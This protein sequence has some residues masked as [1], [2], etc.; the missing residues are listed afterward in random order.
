MIIATSR[1]D[2][3]KLQEELHE[4]ARVQAD[5]IIQNAERQIQQQTARSVAEIR[6]EAVDLSLMI[7]SKL[8]RRNLTKEDNDGL[9]EDAL[10]QIESQ[11][12]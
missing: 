6:R 4:K 7:A 9:I 2:A 11:Q 12:A 10:K 1:A 8:V 5:T 3:A